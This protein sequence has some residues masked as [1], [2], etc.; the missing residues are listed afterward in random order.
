MWDVSGDTLGSSLGASWQP[1]GGLLGTSWGLLEASWDPLGRPWGALGSP[2][3][4]KRPPRGSQEAPKRL[5]RGSQ[6]SPRGAK[7]RPREAQEA[8]KRPPGP[9]LGP[10]WGHFSSKKSLSRRVRL[11]TQ[12]FCVFL[13]LCRRFFDV[14][15][16]FFCVPLPS[17][18]TSSREAATLRKHKKT[19]CFT[20]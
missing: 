1:P 14:F 5:P 12:F 8:P 6:E 15:F 17:R 7:R 19:M 9:L 3:G 13:S 10:F 2:D 18:S 4:A 11:L 16:L 20:M